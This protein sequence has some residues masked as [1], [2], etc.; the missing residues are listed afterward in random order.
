MRQLN[1][2]T[3]KLKKPR[4]FIKKTEKKRD[5]MLFPVI[6]SFFCNLNLTKYV[7]RNLQETRPDVTCLLATV[8]YRKLSQI[9]T[10][11]R[12]NLLIFHAF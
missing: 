5:F 9:I 1:V 6:F 2:F 8:N 12:Q 11:K 4:F 7:K 10:I 3:E